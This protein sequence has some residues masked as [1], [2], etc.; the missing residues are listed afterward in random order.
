MFTPSN[1]KQWNRSME[2]LKQSLEKLDKNQ[3]RMDKLISDPAKLDKVARGMV[4]IIKRT[5]SQNEEKEEQEVPIV[6]RSF[7]DEFPTVSDHHT[8]DLMESKNQTLENESENSFDD[9]ESQ[10]HDVDGHAA[11]LEVEE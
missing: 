5:P 11:T 1:Q 10:D 8:T 4:S 2:K 6:S 7:Y 9:N 3:K